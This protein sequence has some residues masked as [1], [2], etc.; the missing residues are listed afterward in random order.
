[1]VDRLSKNDHSSETHRQE[2][3]EEREPRDDGNNN[4]SRSRIKYVV[5]K[6]NPVTGSRT[7]L[8]GEPPGGLEKRSTETEFA[9]EAKEVFYEEG[10]STSQVTLL[11]PSLRHL[12][13]NTLKK[14]FEHDK[15]SQWAEGEPYLSTMKEPFSLL[16]FYWKE[17]V[18]E[19]QRVENDPEKMQARADLKLLLQHVR[20]LKLDLTLQCESVDSIKR[21][22]YEHLFILFRPGTCVVARPYLNRP[23]VFKVHS[24]STEKK[25]FTLKCWAYDWNGVGLIR[26]YYSFIIKEFDDSRD[27]RELPCYPASY[28]EDENGEV[29]IPALESKLISR[30]LKF[31]KICVRPP[32]AASMCHY[33][34]LIHTEHED[35]DYRRAYFDLVSYFSR[36]V[37][38]V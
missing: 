7:G 17:L 4:A 8:P 6:V 12:V 36:L 28:Y 5:S 27:I 11:A 30:G 34:G 31:R 26:S 23:Q 22:R 13:Y 19:S 16:A 38:W 14:Q 2:P 35:P 1:M 33:E 21:I 29:G 37:Y 10:K 24:Q 18:E 20:A 9:F 32:G 15:N 25:H 3:E